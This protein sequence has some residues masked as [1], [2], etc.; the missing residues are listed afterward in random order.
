MPANTEHPCF[1]Q[2]SDPDVG[3]WRYMDFAKY[4]ALLNQQSLFFS[5][6]DLLGDPYEGTLSKAEYEQLKKTAEIGEKEGKLPPR[7]R[8]RYF[9]VLL[10]SA[11]RARRSIYV[12]CWHIS[13]GESEAMWKLYA[14]SGY[15]IA[16]QSTYQKL[17]AAVTTPAHKHCYI[18]IVTYTDHHSQDMPRGNIFHSVMHKRDSFSHE[19]EC[20]V[21]IWVDPG[22]DKEL[23]SQPA[24]VVIPLDL[25]LLIERV[26]VAPA[27]PVW[28]A[29]T[30]A[31]VTRAYGLNVEVNHSNLIKT[32]YI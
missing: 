7:W 9:D 10:T 26:I 19:R 14:S 8:G 3:I 31:D 12:N 1:P 32:P 28:F 2:P 25:T 22:H 29:D 13:S 17:A 6:L 4:V 16:L 20:R 24:G 21:V 23:E 18:G 30:V 15:A 5:R 27:A 11:R